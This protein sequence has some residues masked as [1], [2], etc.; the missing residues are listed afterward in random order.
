MVVRIVVLVVVMV[1]VVAERAA[2]EI[3]VVLGREKL[4]WWKRDG[5]RE[6]VGGVNMVRWCHVGIT[7]STHEKH[8][9]LHRSAAN[10]Q[11]AMGKSPFFQPARNKQHGQAEYRLTYTSLI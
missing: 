6:M 10:T 4:G 8:S 9:T 3:A 11:V 1:V 5:E 2:R 7:G